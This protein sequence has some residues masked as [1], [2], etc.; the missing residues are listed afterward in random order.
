MNSGWLRWILSAL[1]VSALFFGC[2]R[3]PGEK[4]YE[5]ALE[6]W[7]A[8]NHVRARTLLEKSIRRRAGSLENAEAYNRLGL[9]LWEMGNPEEAA[10]A[11]NESCRLD[12]GRFDVLCNLGVSL[13]A[14]ADFSAAER[15]LR[16]AALMQPGDPRPLAFAGVAYILNSKWDDAERNLRRALQRTPDDPRIQTALALAELH[17]A[18]ADSAL[19]RLLSVARQ[20]PDY[21]PALFNLASIYSD[22]LNNP[23]EARRWLE[24]YLTR[25]SGMDAWSELGRERLE[26]L[27]RPV[28][29]IVYTAP[30]RP[31]RAAA[32][33][34]FQKAL[35]AHK[36]N[37]LDEAAGGYIRSVEADDTYEQAFY[38]LGLVY[39]TQGDMARAGEAFEKA[40]AVNPA[41]V[42]A[43][44]NLA[45]VAH[46]QGNNARA[47]QELAVIREQQPGYQPA[48]D[49]AERIR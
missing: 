2:G 42:A 21:A 44:Y 16:E 1:L 12:A 49:L 41:F 23:T 40:L 43:R 10:D 45:L 20:N 3:Q 32:E 28:S 8:G 33:R 34:L 17:T 6:Q 29:R 14:G 48:I 36:A 15:V 24:L 19:P 13:S 7:Q 30:R 4:L 22:W 35:A 25:A 47:R 37:R 11:F 38:N 26:K 39:Y 5:E 18:G 31:N 9:L 46:R 27:N